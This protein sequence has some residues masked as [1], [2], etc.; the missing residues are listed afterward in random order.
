[1]KYNYGK[2]LF[3]MD[4]NTRNSNQL[5]PI[6]V[7]WPIFIYQITYAER[8]ELDVFITQF[9][10]NSNW[11]GQYL[12]ISQRSADRYRFKWSSFLKRIVPLPVVLQCN[13][14]T[15]YTCFP[16]YYLWLDVPTM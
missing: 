14:W 3:L 10:E 12:F 5:T 2:Y 8:R 15:G 7:K 16:A 4:Q 11:L 1:M 9:V 13:W 6:A